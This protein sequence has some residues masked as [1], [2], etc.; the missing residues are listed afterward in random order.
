MVFGA[1]YE[2]HSPF[3]FSMSTEPEHLRIMRV[4]ERE[5]PD[6]TPLQQIK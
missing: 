4:I 2:D 6:L 3:L 5:A 1:T